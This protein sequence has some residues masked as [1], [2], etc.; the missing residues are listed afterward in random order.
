MMTKRIEREVKRAIAKLGYQP[1]VLL[2]GFYLPDGEFVWGYV[3]K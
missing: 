2:L 1:D 3:V